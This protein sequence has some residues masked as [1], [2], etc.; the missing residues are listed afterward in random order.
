MRAFGF[1]ATAGEHKLAVELHQ[2]GTASSD[3]LFGMEVR[4][5]AGTSPS[6][7][8]ARSVNG[9]VHLNWNADNNWRL[10]SAPALSGP[11]L[12]VPIPIGSRLGTFTLPS[13]SVTNR[14]FWRLDYITGP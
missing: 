10:R 4:L 2:A 8:I 9:D 11:Y 3:V 1:T 13:A 14:S 5:V 7:S 6:L 12:D